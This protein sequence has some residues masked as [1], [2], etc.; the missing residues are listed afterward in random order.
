MR[1]ERCVFVEGSQSLPLLRAL[2][3]CGTDLSVAKESEHGPLDRHGL[4]LLSERLGIVEGGSSCG[5]AWNR[6]SARRT[7]SFYVLSLVALV[8]FLNLSSVSSVYS[9][10]PLV[11]LVF[12]SCSALRL[13]LFDLGLRAKG[14]QQPKNAR[15]PNKQT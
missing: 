15:G 12:C 11:L 5:S 1:S 14:Y 13:T 8:L 7:P 2:V 3:R 9:S 4:G 6:K 10:S